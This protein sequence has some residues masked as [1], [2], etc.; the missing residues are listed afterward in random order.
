MSVAVRVVTGISSPTCSIAGWLSTTTSDGEDSTLTF[1]KLESA[2]RTTRGC[3][4]WPSRRLK[5]GS[6][7]E[8][9]AEELSSAAE[10]LFGLRPTSLL[11]KK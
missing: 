1:V 6:T 9:M 2:S 11:E 3:A 10:P 8:M 4:S 5:P 7:R